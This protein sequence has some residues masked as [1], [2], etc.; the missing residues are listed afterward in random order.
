MVLLDFLVRAH[1]AAIAAM[2]ARRNV[3]VQEGQGRADKEPNPR[4]AAVEGRAFRVAANAK[5]LL[6][7]CDAF[8]FLHVHLIAGRAGD[9]KQV[10]KT[11]RSRDAAD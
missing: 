10:R 1:E 11:L 5:W 3:R 2:A 8:F 4:N 7:L 6:R 9:K